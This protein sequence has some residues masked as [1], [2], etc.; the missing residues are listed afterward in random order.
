MALREETK[1]KHKI[2]AR[3]TA[4]EMLARIKDKLAEPT[5]KLIILDEWCKGC[6]ICVEFCPTKS[7]KL[8]D[9]MKAR[10][11]NED[12][13]RSC[14]L[15]EYLCPDLAII[16]TELKDIDINEIP[17]SS[18]PEFKKKGTKKCQKKK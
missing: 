7:I 2:Y 10:L 6:G 17:E 5:E 3:T 11:I 13:C 15:C 18:N 16:V 9:H 1:D 8:N 14:G 4:L 12:S